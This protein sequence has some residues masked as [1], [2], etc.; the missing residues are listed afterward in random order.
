MI[1]SDTRVIQT[2]AS[3]ANR[4]RFT[5]YLGAGASIEA[6][7]PT[8]QQI[9]DRIRIS[10]LG[11]KPTPK[12]IRTVDRELNWATPSLR[13]MTAIQKAYPNRAQRVQFFRDSLLQIQP[14]FAH[15]ATAALMR[16]QVL[17]RV[18]I[19]TNFDKLLESAFVQQGGPECRPLRTDDELQYYDDRAGHFLLKLHGDCDTENIL[20]T[21]E[22]TRLV[23]DSKRLFLEKL[24]RGAGLVVMGAAA[25]ESSVSTL[26]KFLM[27]DV[28]QKLLEFGLFWG[29]YVGAS[30]PETIADPE[31][32]AL[33]ESKLRDQVNPEIVSLMKQRNK[34]NPSFAFFPVWG[35]GNYFFDLATAIKSK[36]LWGGIERY[37]DHEMRLRSVFRRAG[38]SPDGVERHLTKL[39][40]QRNRTNK[41]FP[42]FDERRHVICNATRGPLRVRAIYADI[43]ERSMMS[44]PQFETA[45][46][47]TVSPEDTCITAGGGVAYGLLRKAGPELLL[48]ELGK[49][50]RSPVAQGDVVVT[51]GGNLPLHYVF[52]AAA[53]KIN[54]DGTSTVTAADVTRTVTNVLR[55]A[56]ALDVTVVWLPLLGSGT[57]GFHRPDS[58]RS[59]LQA[60]AAWPG[61][62]NVL[63]NVTILEEAELYRDEVTRAFTEVLGAP[64]TITS[65]P[66]VSDED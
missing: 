21:E 6:G 49:L 11:E 43:T 26:F 46:R 40:Q 33:V 17:S 20:N 25:Y 36:K 41:S 50:A 65:P 64:F 7:V 18:A 30:R 31:I 66:R 34:D 42:N 24:L 37:L 29:V 55:L 16:D 51:S 19:T 3:D 53:A 54:V 57:A 52:H 62:L 58:L 14:S 63:I 28:D 32:R 15:H 12:Q 35:A 4:G 44:A 38:L 1:E 5:I 10:R 22:E 61:D 8:G 59:T 56:Q 60:I 47:A 23:T 39:R 27:R 48:P 9:C 45:R 2:L 13:Y